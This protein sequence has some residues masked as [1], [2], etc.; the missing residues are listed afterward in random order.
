MHGSHVWK[1]WDT[2]SLRTLLSSCSVNAMVGNAEFNTVPR[3]SFFEIFIL[4]FNHQPNFDLSLNYDHCGISPLFNCSLCLSHVRISSGLD[5]PAKWAII[6]EFSAKP[7]IL[8]RD[9]CGMCRVRSWKD[10]S[11]QVEEHRGESPVFFLRRSVFFSNLYSLTTMG[12]SLSCTQIR[13]SSCNISKD[14]KS[15]AKP[16]LFGWT[17]K[18]WLTNFWMCCAEVD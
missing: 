7:A 11:P 10:C 3:T 16:L 12:L 13:S 2:C 8:H 17:Q 14:L 1:R 6:Q 18:F 5:I 4:H 9:V 15:N